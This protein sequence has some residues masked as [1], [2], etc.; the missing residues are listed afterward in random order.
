MEVGKDIEAGGFEETGCQEG[1]RGSHKK[2]GKEG[3][4]P[5]QVA[6]VG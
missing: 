6:K 3:S 5:R 2:D 4:Y 1:R